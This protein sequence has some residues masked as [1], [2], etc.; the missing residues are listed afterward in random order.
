[1]IVRQGD[2]VIHS[3]RS[4]CSM[5]ARVLRLSQPSIRANCSRFAAAISFVC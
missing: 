3:V 4:L 5:V 1:V 2:V